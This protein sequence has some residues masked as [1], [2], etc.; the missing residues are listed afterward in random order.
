MDQALIALGS[1]LTRQNSTA[2]EWICLLGCISSLAVSFFYRQYNDIAVSLTFGIIVLVAVLDW[3]QR[4]VWPLLLIIGAAKLLAIP[5]E[6]ILTQLSGEV[7]YGPLMFYLS[8]ALIDVAM[9]LCITAY[10]KDST[11]LGWFKIDN[12]KPFPQ[13]QLMSAVLMTS[14]FYAFAQ[15]TEWLVYF[16]DMAN[17]GK[18]PFLFGMKLPLFYAFQNEVKLALKLAF[19]LLLWSLLLD[20][21]R[22]SVL[23]RLQRRA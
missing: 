20:A 3:K 5:V 7:V 13:T 16:L 21:D 14:A 1:Q 8:S 19:D 15:A 17:G 10:H 12:P 22:W 23:R 4:T 6:L 18:L 9:L 2:K 11:V